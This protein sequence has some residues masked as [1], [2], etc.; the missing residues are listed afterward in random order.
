M[1]DIVGLG[2]GLQAAGAMSGQLGGIFN[3]IADGVK[4]AE[5]NI[6]CAKCGAEIPNGAKFCLE[7]GEKL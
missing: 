1:G 6:K 4:T 2:I 5:T 3:D 7:C